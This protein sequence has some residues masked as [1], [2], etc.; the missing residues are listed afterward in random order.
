MAVRSKRRR[1][2]DIV[3]GVVIFL[4]GVDSEMP[5]VSNVIK[6]VTLLGLILFL[7]DRDTRLS[8]IILGIGILREKVKMLRVILRVL[9]GEKRIKLGKRRI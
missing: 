2:A 4:Q 3:V 8:H 6:L 7:I 5:P 1:T 9:I